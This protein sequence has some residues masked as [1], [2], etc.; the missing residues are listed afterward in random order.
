MFIDYILILA[1]ESFIGILWDTCH[2]S[3]KIQRET[4]IY[5]YFLGKKLFKLNH[6]TV[7]T[8]KLKILILH[9]SLTVFP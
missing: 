8:L 2:I 7:K 4:H 6:F 1:F 9:I 5:Q 3:S